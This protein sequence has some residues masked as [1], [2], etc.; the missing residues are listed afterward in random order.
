MLPRTVTFSVRWSR[1]YPIG[2][3][4]GIP[5]PSRGMDRPINPVH[6]RN[7][8]AVPDPVRAN[9]ETI[10][11]AFVSSGRTICLPETL[12]VKGVPHAHGQHCSIRGGV[13]DDRRRHVHL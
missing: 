13:H 8:S 2:A 5:S 1:C 7:S 10:S 9:I 4:S 12:T 6:L 3:F 11:S